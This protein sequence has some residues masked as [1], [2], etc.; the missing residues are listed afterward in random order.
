LDL[1]VCGNNT[2]FVSIDRD[3]GRRAGEFKARTT[4]PCQILCRLPVL[5]RAARG[6][7]IVERKP[8]P[9][10]REA[11]LPEPDFEQRQGFFVL[12][13]W[14]GWLTDEVLAGFHLNERQLQTI[15]YLKSTGVIIKNGKWI[16]LHSRAEQR[17]AWSSQP[18]G[19]LVTRA[20]SDRGFGM[21]R[22]SPS[23]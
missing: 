12:T 22:K 15:A 21:G 3:I 19:C 20:D 17:R 18:C 10:C 1:I 4:L 14:H 13:L 6:D 23:G 8:P 2:G 9:Q 16:D 5:S 11:N 7:T